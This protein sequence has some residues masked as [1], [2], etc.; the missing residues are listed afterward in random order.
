IGGHNA[1]MRP[2][3]LLLAAI[4]TCSVFDILIILKKQR[5]VVQDVKITVTGERADAVPAP[6]AEI[7]IKFTFWGD[8]QPEKVEKA[9]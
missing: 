9:V 4:G 3:Q 7:E 2:M 8:L 6:F 1:G 5:Q